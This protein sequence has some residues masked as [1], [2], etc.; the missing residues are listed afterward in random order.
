M[1]VW[2]SVDGGFAVYLDAGL[3]VALEAENIVITPSPTGGTERE[4]IIWVK[5]ERVALSVRVKD[6]DFGN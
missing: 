1:M 5:H 6:E 4:T 2:P 3:N